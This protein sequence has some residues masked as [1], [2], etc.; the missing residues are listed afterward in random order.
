MIKINEGFICDFCGFIN[1][2]AKKTC[3]NHCLNCILS[4]HVDLDKPGDR[5]STC[6][7]KMLVKNVIVDMKKSFFTLAYE[8]EK[9]G[10]II[11]NKSAIDDDHEKI[12]EIAEKLANEKIRKR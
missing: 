3:R 11:K 4:K 1:P 6:L 12:I 9:C 2:P 7:G 10:K 8:C 5:K